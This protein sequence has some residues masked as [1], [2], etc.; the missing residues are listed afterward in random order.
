MGNLDPRFRADRR[1]RLQTVTRNGLEAELG[2]LFLAWSRSDLPGG[3]PLEGGRGG[4]AVH[5]LAAASQS[6]G[7]VKAVLRPFR[8]GGF[9]R[10]FTNDLYLGRSPR[11]FAELEVTQ[12]LLDAGV[13]VVEPLGA[14]A[15]WVGPVAYR[16]AIAT[17]FVEGSRNLWS[18]LRA[19]RKP[20]REV[21]C[22]AVAAATRQFH[23][24]GAVHPDLNLQNYL[25]REE[26]GR[27]R[28]WILDCDGVH[29]QPVGPADR[30][31]A[32]ERICRSIR[33]L[34]P[35]AEFLTLACIE[36]LHDIARAS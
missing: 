31:A 34:D 27:P 6:S 35:I 3:E 22:V 21:A 29:L 1:G 14:A 28:I 10:H 32:F 12:H 19:V 20:A 5:P 16:A 26:D 4:V 2:A 23:D 9:V 18:Y 24:S 15:H 8:R 36:A 7:E 11:S 17:R 25:V 30:A 33:K 13:P